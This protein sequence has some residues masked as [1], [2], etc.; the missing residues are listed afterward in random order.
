MAVITYRLSRFGTILLTPEQQSSQYLSLRVN[1]VLRRA[2]E[3]RNPRF[4]PPRNGWLYWL[5][6]DS[7][8]YV[9]HSGYAE[10]YKQ[11]WQLWSFP[12]SNVLQS[13]CRMS[14]DMYLELMRELA[15][16]PN[17]PPLPPTIPPTTPPFSLGAR[18]QGLGTTT[19]TF[20]AFND[21]D[22]DVTL[23]WGPPPPVD[24]C[25]PSPILPEPPAPIE[26]QLPPPAPNMPAPPPQEALRPPEAPTGS[27]S[28]GASLIPPGFPPGYQ[29]SPPNTA[30][31]LRLAFAA[32]R[33]VNGATCQANVSF[34]HVQEIDWVGSTPI[35]GDFQMTQRETGA[36]SCGFP[37]AEFVLH[38]RGQPYA[39]LT[40]TTRLGANNRVW[41]CT[42]VQRI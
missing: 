1:C 6:M 4:I 37:F 35:A 15:K 34:T 3:Y 8:F 5:G 17:I 32:T 7:D 29:S 23:N 22:F 25:T 24:G 28:I 11:S 9:T 36:R 40:Q 21:G 38:Y 20:V 16:K 33:V 26:D 13:L 2:V 18:I 14:N 27:P 41:P 30:G 10:W 39:P 19:L 42:S 12:E 31:R